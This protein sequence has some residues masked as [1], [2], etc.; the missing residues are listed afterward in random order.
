[1]GTTL[2]VP[3]PGRDAEALPISQHTP[4]TPLRPQVFAGFL[5]H[6]PDKAFV[7]ELIRS[8]TY[9]F[10]I[11]YTG[12]HTTLIANNLR[13]ASEHPLVVDEALQKEVKNLR[14][15]GP[16]SSPPYHNLRCSGL[17]VI[18]KNDGTWRIINHLSAPQ[19]SSIN[20]YI[21][22][23]ECSL[24][25][26]TIDE[27]IHI[28]QSLGRGALMAKVDLKSAFRLCPVRQED[29]HLLGIKWKGKYYI[30]KCLPFGLRSAPYLFNKVADAL[31]W[32]LRHYFKV[33][34]T[35]HYLDD[36]FFAGPAGSL[37]CRR[38][39][40]DMLSLCTALQA[41][42]KAEK[43]VA[44][45]TCLVL[46]GIEL[47]TILM[48]ARLPEEKLSALLEELRG[49]N[50]LHLNEGLCTKR[51]LLSLIGKLAFAC[52]V[53]PA[54]R[55]FLRRLLDLAHSREELDV[56]FPLSTEA[57][58]DILWWLKFARS[59]N[60]T[61]FFLDPTWTPA[62]Q[63][64]LFTDAAGTLGYGAYWNGAWFSK[65]WPPHLLQKPI[66]WKE[67]Y[68]IVMAAETW[69]SQ[70]S[71]KRLLFHCD[72]Q[73]IVEIW[74]SGLSRS[75]DLMRLVRALFFVAARHNFNVIIRH[76]PGIDNCIAD[77]LSRLQLT[78]FRTLA[79]EANPLPS[80]T[81]AN[82]TFS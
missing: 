24:H 26:C 60:G 50:S 81:P 42:L 38:A 31:E 47:D 28:C 82:P 33:N 18:P 70:W 55:I 65:A 78:R 79:P 48:R 16:Y 67:L 13:S 4:H 59:W 53:V 1:M 22:P 36:F 64:Q 30:D 35:F 19:G 73:A 56:P 41:P 80:P 37:A 52:K 77:S 61:A 10:N 2:S 20:D 46:L 3:A 51:R 27:A 29:W 71:G 57:R 5:T 75:S 23:L 12:P 62:H 15:A 72:N 58:E 68:A 25:Y 34:H 32:I 8:L 45:T 17:G 39:L 6:H 40:Q 69:G 63:L 76:I 74:Q 66:E 43:I 7:S 54:G 21:D 14:I 49:F 11:G 44:P 9:G